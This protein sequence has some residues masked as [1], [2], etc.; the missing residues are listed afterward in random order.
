MKELLIPTK[1]SIGQVITIVIG[2]IVLLGITYLYASTW[3]HYI[4]GVLGI[5]VFVFSL[6]KAGITS[7]GFSY[8]RS[9]IGF[10]APWDKI[11]NVYVSREKD[12]TL[13]FSGHGSYE[14]CFRKEDYDQIMNI[15]KQKLA[16]EVVK[17]I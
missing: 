10:L 4:L 13:Y 17:E 16:S 7:K 5:L 1:K 15:L 8:T 3:I 6:F 12:V 11:K 2:V 14:L 9:Y